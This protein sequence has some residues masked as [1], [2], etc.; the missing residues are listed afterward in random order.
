MIHIKADGFSAKLSARCGRLADGDVSSSREATDASVPL[1]PRMGLGL[2]YLR[3][4][5]ILFL[6]KSRSPAIS[7]ILYG[8]YSSRK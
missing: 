7:I 3:L 5:Y 2:S 4:Y 6:S 1:V 8:D